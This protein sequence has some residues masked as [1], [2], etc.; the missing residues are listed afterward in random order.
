MQRRALRRGEQKKEERERKKREREKKRE[1]RERKRERD[2]RVGAVLC[3][4]A[5]EWDYSP[6][7]RTRVG[8]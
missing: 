8:L 4:S 2:E 6:Y 3:V 7:S 5:S 1:K